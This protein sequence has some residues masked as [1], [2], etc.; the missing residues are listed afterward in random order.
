MQLT[1]DYKAKVFADRIEIRDQTI[2]IEDFRKLE[3]LVKEIA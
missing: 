2:T 1:R 3:K